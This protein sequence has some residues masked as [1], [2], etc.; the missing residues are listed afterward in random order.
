MLKKKTTSSH[1][2]KKI[3][4]LINNTQGHEGTWED[5]VSCLWGET[6][7]REPFSSAHTALDAPCSRGL[8]LCYQPSFNTRFNGGQ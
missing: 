4:I 6:P 7:P 3:R 1:L 2:K 8:P 5:A